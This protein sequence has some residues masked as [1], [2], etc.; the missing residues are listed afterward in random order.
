MA[1]TKYT[2]FDL[3]ER[4]GFEITTRGNI[5]CPFC[6]EPEKRKTLH[7][8]EEDDYWRC[9][10]CKSSGG[11]LHF[12]SKYALG[13]DLPPSKEGRSE[14]ANQLRDFMGDSSAQQ[15]AAPTEKKKKAPKVPVASDAKLHAVYSAMAQIPALQLTSDH[16]KELKRRGLSDE[17][18]E[19]NQYRS[20][21]NNPVVPDCYV[22]MYETAGGENLRSELFSWHSS[23]NVQF[24]LMIAHTLVAAGYD[25]TGVPGFFKFGD[26]W[27]LWFMNP[28]IL[29]PTRNMHGQI[30]I[31]QVRQK[32]TPKY[33][34]LSCSN[35]PGTVTEEVSRCHYPLGNA[36]ISPDVPVLFTEG[37]L[38]AD[39]ACQLYYSP[40]VF[41]AIPGICTTKDLIRNLRIIKKA[42]N[43]TEVNN[44]LDMDRLTN[45]NVR[46][47][48]RDLV[49]GIQDLGMTVR[50]MYWG[51]DYATRKLM[52]LDLIAKLRKVPVPEAA[53]NTVFDKLCA[54]AEALNDAGINPCKVKDA[55]G[56]STLYYW[57]SETKG[58]D[59]FLM[60]RSE[61]YIV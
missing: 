49:T 5:S 55:S 61:D 3:V 16:R 33:L 38:K 2:I 4:L 58:I 54:V 27:C 60:H 35:L 30:V 1:T 41:F 20:I 39:V 45:P 18:I 8:K 19:R 46:N 6:T 14:V 28:G 36:P 57:E 26:K 34:T 24:G 29:I 52:A 23:R 22:E 44:A 32:R 56:K 47:G 25:L 12:Y 42:Y 17:V 37:P 59:D 40:V 53:I 10:K 13:Y 11:V 9:N 48:S 7:L 43:I 15:T 50:D 21:P 31:W 51:T